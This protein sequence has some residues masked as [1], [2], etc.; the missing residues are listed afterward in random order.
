MKLIRLAAHR[1]VP[2]PLLLCIGNFDGVH[3]GHRA[4]I[5]RLLEVRRDGEAVGVMSFYPHTRQLI[6]GEAPPFITP[7][8]EQARL[9]RT[10]GVDFW[11]LLHFGKALR[12]MAAEDF[13]RQ[14]LYQQCQMRA[15]AIGDDFRFGHGGRGDFALLQRMAQMDDW[16][17]LRQETV[18]W[19][20]QRV[21]SSA[22]RAALAAYD[23][24]TAQELLGH[25]VLYAGRVRHGHGRSRAQGMLPTANV[26]VAPQWSVA[27]G[28]Y[29]VQARREGEETWRAGVANLGQSPSF[30]EGTKIRRLEVHLFDFQ[31]DLYGARLQVKVLSFIR[32]TQRFADVQSLKEQIASDAAQARAYFSQA[33]SRQQSLTENITI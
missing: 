32:P 4:L 20:G 11:L 8:R 13:V 31:D 27:D 19:Q 22:I 21:S 6:S 15:L 25:A 10:A 28:V 5:Q 30:H 2:Q 3:R 26:H 12:A 29:V 23:L 9:L 16:R 17:L 14:V 18:L 24:R 7:L 33:Q 1:R